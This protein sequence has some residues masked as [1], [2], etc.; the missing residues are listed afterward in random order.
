MLTMGAEMFPV[1]PTVF[2]A[3][4]RH[5]VTDRESVSELTTG[6]GG[7]FRAFHADSV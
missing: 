7:S 2:V 3:N 6:D 1:V 4:D 5:D